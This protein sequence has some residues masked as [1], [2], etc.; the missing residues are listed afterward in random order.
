MS[1]FGAPIV[2]NKIITNLG[3]VSRRFSD[4]CKLLFEIDYR[5]RH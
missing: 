1:I 4:D 3:Q 5:Q 2:K